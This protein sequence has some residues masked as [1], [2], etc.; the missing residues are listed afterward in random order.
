MS[1]LHAYCYNSDPL[2][3][4]CDVAK[5]DFRLSVEDDPSTGRWVPRGNGHEYL[6][7]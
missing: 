4:L 1:I 5:S 6:D 7:T 2:T 3:R